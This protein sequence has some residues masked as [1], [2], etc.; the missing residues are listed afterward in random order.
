[1][2]KIIGSTFVILF[3]SFAAFSQTASESPTLKKE[4]AKC[5]LSYEECANKMG[6]TVEECKALC[7][8]VCGTTA[9]K[10]EVLEADV[11]AVSKNRGKISSML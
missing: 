1:M 11:I 2:K 7:N 3:L 6:I 9:V 5:S 10:G 8:K 4:N